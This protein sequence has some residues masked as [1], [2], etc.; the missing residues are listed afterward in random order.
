LSCVELLNTSL[1]PKIEILQ[2][3]EIIYS[4]N[5][6]EN[7]GRT[8]LNILPGSIASAIVTYAH[9]SVVIVKR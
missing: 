8:G 6:V 3:A 5:I 2:Y 4:F 1:L 9:C 7:S